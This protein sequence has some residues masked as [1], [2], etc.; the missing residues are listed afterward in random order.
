MQDFNLETALLVT[1]DTKEIKAQQAN[2]KKTFKAFIKSAD[3]A[4]SACQ[5]LFNNFAH[6]FDAEGHDKDY[7]LAKKKWFAAVGFKNAEQ[8]KNESGLNLS[9]Y[10]S[11]MA[12]GAKEGHKAYYD[13][14]ELR[15][16]YIN[17]PKT[18]AGAKPKAKSGTGTGEGESVDPV[19]NIPK[20]T[21]A[22]LEAINKASQLAPEL[23]DVLAGEMLEVIKAAN[24]Q[25][26]I[27]A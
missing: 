3:S 25:L 10:F 9:A 17:R 12:F 6:C 16:D 18:K 27:A 22:L 11:I 13:F 1:T 14:A 21:S 2:V 24:D 4:A 19:A 20:V 23:Q 26:K 5:M 7:A 15:T 8:M